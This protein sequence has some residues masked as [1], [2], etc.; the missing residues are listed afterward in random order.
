MRPRG[1]RRS[2]GKPLTYG[3][4]DEFLSHFGLD[5]LGDLPGLSELKGAGLLA[6]DLPPD[7]SVPDPKNVAALMPD[8]LPLEHE[9]EETAELDLD[10]DLLVDDDEV[11]DD[12]EEPTR[13]SK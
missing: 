3:T 4:T 2:P 1:R 13:D 8:E 12:N 11:Q 9:E 6:S 5:S 7:F 10:D